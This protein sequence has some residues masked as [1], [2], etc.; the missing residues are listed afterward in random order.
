MVTIDTG[1]TPD[2][3]HWPERRARRT[4]LALI[5]HHAGNILAPLELYICIEHCEED[6]RNIIDNKFMNICRDEEKPKPK[7]LNLRGNRR[8]IKLPTGRYKVRIISNLRPSLTVYEISPGTVLIYLAYQM[9]IHYGES[10]DISIDE[11]WVSDWMNAGSTDS[12]KN[13]L[14][15]DIARYKDGEFQKVT[16]VGREILR[17]KKYRKY[18]RQETSLWGRE[19]G[20][21]DGEE[22]EVVGRREGALAFKNELGIRRQ[23][24]GEERE[25]K[26]VRNMKYEGLDDGQGN[27]DEDECDDHKLIDRRA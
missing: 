27:T 23:A 5:T 14:V 4:P 10:Q 19:E 8:N 6:S 15:F 13:C 25:I 20:S 9:G 21:R 3:G 11:A 18:L 16:C 24:N 22:A 7:L 26:G 17:N 1:D 2:P 12:R